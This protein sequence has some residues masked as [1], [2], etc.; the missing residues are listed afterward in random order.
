MRPIPSV[1]S[2]DFTQCLLVLIETLACLPEESFFELF[3]DLIIVVV[4]MNLSYLKVR[5][6]LLPKLALC[7]FF[8]CPCV[9]CPLSI[10]DSY[11]FRLSISFIFLCSAGCVPNTRCMR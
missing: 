2:I 3:Y 8:Q 11:I 7:R 9:H 4:L 10:E 6:L 5:S 1:S